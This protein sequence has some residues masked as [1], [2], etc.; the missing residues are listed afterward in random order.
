[1]R[2][3]AIM[4]IVVG[5]LIF[6]LTAATAMAV[7]GKGGSK[8]GETTASKVTLCHKGKTITVGGP[9]VKG[10]SKHGDVAGACATTTPG[11]GTTTADPGTTTGTTTADPGTTTGT[12]DG[13]AVAPGA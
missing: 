7:P 1:M 11:G 3:T 13:V 6:A 10:H 9:A 2:R 5:A 12:T 4:M 8:G